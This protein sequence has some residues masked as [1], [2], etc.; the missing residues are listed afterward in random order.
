MDNQ[1]LIPALRYSRHLDFLIELQ[2]FQVFS[3][4]F[5]PALI[6]FLLN[7]YKKLDNAVF[8]DEKVKQGSHLSRLCG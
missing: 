2:R 5:F 8:T 7:I 1:N 3:E 4:F 6:V